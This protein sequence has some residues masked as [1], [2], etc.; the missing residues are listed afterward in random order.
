[1]GSGGLSNIARP[2]PLCVPEQGFEPDHD[3]YLFNGGE[4]EDA[5]LDGSKEASGG[6]D[7]TELESIS[8]EE[9]GKG[10]SRHRGVA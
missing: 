1:M 3:L 4:T 9:T 2:A 5:A 6:E 7:R 10:F 8:G